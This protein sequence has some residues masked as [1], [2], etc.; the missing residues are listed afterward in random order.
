MCSNSG[1]RDGAGEDVRPGVHVVEVP[2]EAFRRALAEPDLGAHVG[3]ETD[4]VVEHASKV[5]V[6]VTLQAERVQQRGTF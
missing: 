2:P 1:D 3:R 5:A 6:I 4:D